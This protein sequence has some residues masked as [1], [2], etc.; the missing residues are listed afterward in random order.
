MGWRPRSDA[1]P[2]DADTC[3]LFEIAMT[4]QHLDAAQV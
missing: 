3:R 4:E 2:T 1:L